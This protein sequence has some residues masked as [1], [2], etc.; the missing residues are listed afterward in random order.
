MQNASEP[1]PPSLIWRERAI[2]VFLLG[3]VFALGFGLFAHKVSDTFQLLGTVSRLL[4][5]LRPYLLILSGVLGGVL[6][7]GGLRWIGIVCILVAFGG[8]GV[9]ALDHRART[10]APG[11]SADLT[12]LWFNI[13][14]DNAVPAAQL[15]AAVRASGADVVAFAEAEPAFEPAVALSDLYPHRYGCV[16]LVDCEILILSRYPLYDARSW[17]LPTGS[18]RLVRATLNHPT[19]GLVPMVWVHLTKPWYQVVGNRE[20]KALN[21]ALR[22]SREGRMIVMGDFNAAPW[23]LRLDKITRHR[24][25]R[26]APVPVGTWPSEAGALGVPIDHVLVRGDARILDLSAWGADLGSNHRGLRAEITLAPAA[27]D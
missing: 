9:L 8:L 2:G 6:V 26:M 21:N 18:D 5:S 1:L 20:E 13:F 11:T 25:L 10:S 17:D 12:V 22:W 16:R 3:L 23:S 19:L 15:E 7:W 27:V 4:D 24:R 14:S